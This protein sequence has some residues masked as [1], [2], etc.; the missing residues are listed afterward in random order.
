MQSTIICLFIFISMGIASSLSIVKSFGIVLA[1]SQLVLGSRASR[2]RRRILERRRV[3]IIKASMCAYTHRLFGDTCPVP[4]YNP[5]EYQAELWTFHEAHCIPN[6]AHC[7]PKEQIYSIE[8]L[9]VFAFIIILFIL[10]CLN[11]C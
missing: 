7:I 10:T 4:S 9:F 8:G 3:A 6:E 1:S 11:A 5:P 2:R